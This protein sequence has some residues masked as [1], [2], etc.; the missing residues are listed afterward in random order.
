MIYNNRVAYKVDRRRIL[1][2]AGERG[3]HRRRQGISRQPPHDRHGQ[4][5]WRPLSLILWS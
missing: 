4:R 2:P 5:L 3:E 1:R